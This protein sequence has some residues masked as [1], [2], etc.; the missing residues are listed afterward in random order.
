MPKD[1]DS[2]VGI[3]EARVRHDGTTTTLALTGEFDLAEIDLV[4]AKFAEAC[5]NGSSRVVIDL[6]ELTFIDST[7]ISF[8]LSATKE[9]EGGRLSFVACDAPAVRRVFAITGVADLFGGGRE[10]TPL[11]LLC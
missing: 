2:N 11:T 3:L 5:G 4:R 10:E 1:S 8:L 7:G 9:D 6:R